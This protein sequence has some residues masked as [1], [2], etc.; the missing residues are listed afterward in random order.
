[1]SEPARKDFAKGTKTDIAT[2]EAQIKR[3]LLREGAEAVAIMEE[4]TQAVVAFH[5]NGRNIR[6]NLPLPSRHDEKFTHY[7]V[8]NQRGAASKL[9]PRSAATADAAWMQASRER[10]RQ[11][12]LCI[13]AKL[14]A[15]A[16]EIE[17][18]DEAF[19]SH[20]VMPDGRTVGEHTIGEMRAQLEGKPMRPL[21]AG[22]S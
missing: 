7:Q 12:H 5:L 14:E 19:L 15:I 6:F 3:M 9:T 13:K 1:M 11:L 10:W 18:F 20:V 17:T 8:V 22:P 2:S 16:Q 4:R 21:L